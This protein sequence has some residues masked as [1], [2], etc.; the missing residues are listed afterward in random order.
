MMKNS[1]LCLMGAALSGCAIVSPV[2]SKKMNVTSAPYGTT[3]RGEAASLFTLTNARGHEVKITNYGGTI[4]AVNVPDRDGKLGDVV[5]GMDSL[6]DYEE[7][8]PFFGCI[9]G[10]YANRIAKGKFTL[11]GH[12]YTLA[13]NNGPNHLHGG[14]VGF[15]KK[16]WTAKPF[17]TAS[18]VGVE[19]TGTSADGEEGYPGA[20]ALKVVYTW[21]NDD[22]L[23]IDYTATTDKPT[24]INLT[25]HSYFNLAG[26]DSGTA[27]NH[28]LTLHASAFT[29]TDAVAIPTGEIRQVA[30]TPFDFTTPH[31]IGERINANDEQIRFG[32]GYDH[33]FVVDGHPG[34]L[35][36]TAFA[37]DPT[38]GRTMTIETTEPGVQLYTANFLS[39]LKGKGGAVYKKRDAFCLETQHYPDSPNQPEFPSTVLR[40]GD[41]FKSTTT[42]RFGVKK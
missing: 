40:P 11:D 21:D 36:P 23:R 32:G 31:V 8:S 35:R 5:L 10:R 19:L 25:N 1:L 16:V 39:G 13:V 41:T 7:R 38:S 37:Y 26:H 27:L 3:K 9:T 14:K 24:V 33:N 30:G 17:K 15:D 20:L 12:G 34:S 22:E 4:T 6:K 29:P 28:Q 2:D 18:T 42:L